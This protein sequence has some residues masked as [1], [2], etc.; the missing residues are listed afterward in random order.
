[1]GLLR[2]FAD[3]VLIGSGTLRSSPEGTWLPEK[4]FPPAAA[5]FAELRRARERPEKPEVAILTG[6]GS[7]D[8]AHPLLESGA[9]V[10][11]ASVEPPAS[12]ASFRPHPRSSHSARTRAS[13]HVPS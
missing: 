3:V 13:T 11:R 12:K 4:V 6:R 10:L 9:L 8:A 1:M 5:A 7:I 2:A